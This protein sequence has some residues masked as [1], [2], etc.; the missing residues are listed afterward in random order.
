MID[1]LNNVSEKE[2]TF[3][4]LQKVRQEYISNEKFNPDIIEGI[5]NP[6]AK[7]SPMYAPV[8]KSRFV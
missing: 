3:K 6:P 2:L 7:N 5:S 8:F 1:K 4:N